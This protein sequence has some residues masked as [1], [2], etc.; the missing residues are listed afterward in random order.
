LLQSLEG[1]LVAPKS[2]R[3]VMCLAIRKEEEITL[4]ADG[5]D[6]QVALGVLEEFLSR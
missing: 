1:R 6:E 3:G 2:I 4:I 5:M